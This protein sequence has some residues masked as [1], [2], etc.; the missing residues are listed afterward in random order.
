MTES[1]LLELFKVPEGCPPQE[2]LGDLEFTAKQLCLDVRSPRRRRAAL[3]ALYEY[4]H[5]LIMDSLERS[6]SC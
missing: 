6:E 1:Q 2:T 4:R 5:Q 3:L